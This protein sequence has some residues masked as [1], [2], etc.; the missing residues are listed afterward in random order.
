MISTIAISQ[1]ENKTI[2]AGLSN[3]L[4]DLVIDAF[5]SDGNLKVV[6]EADADGVLYG[7]LTSYKREAYN[8]DEADNV[9]QYVVKLNFDVTLKKRDSEENFWQEQFY[10]EGVFDAFEETEE[11]GQMMAVEKLVQDI[12]NRTTKSW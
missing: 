8:Y 7:I 4:T 3:T 12:L 1:F 10:S 6:S 11:D 5:I 2:E 9:A